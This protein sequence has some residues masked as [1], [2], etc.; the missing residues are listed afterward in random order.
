MKL[1]ETNRRRAL[2]RRRKLMPEPR[3]VSTPETEVLME[4]PAE[5]RVEARPAADI[6]PLDQPPAED[7]AT[8]Q[9]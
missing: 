4:G 9:T 1:N 5:Q 7:P 2:Q 8:A 6:T 3:R